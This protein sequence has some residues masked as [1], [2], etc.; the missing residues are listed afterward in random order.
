M[1]KS[2]ILERI[3]TI[4]LF[5][6]LNQSG[7]PVPAAE[8]TALP[9]FTDVFA[10]IG[11]EQS[12]DESLSTFSGHMK[13]IARI[14]ENADKNTLV[15]LDELGSGTDPQDNNVIR[16]FSWEGRPESF[17]WDGSDEADNIVE[18]G[19]YEML[20]CS[21][22]SAGNRCEVKIPGIIS[23][24]SVVKAFLTMESSAMSP[25]GDG[26]KDIQLFNVKLSP[27]EGVGKLALC[28]KERG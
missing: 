27:P 21:E 5:S 24:T 6:L 14:L 18:D 22:D 10:D 15:L 4:A 2:S 17:E 8:G 26:K 11:D 20:I 3:E 25:N 1:E 7:F 13:N 19:T 16:V 23:D 12:L 28:H 9:V